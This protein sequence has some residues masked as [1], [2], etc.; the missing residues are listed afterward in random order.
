MFYKNNL[1]TGISLTCYRRADYL[2]TVIDSLYSSIK[3]SN[4]DISN[5]TLYVSIDYYDNVIPTIISN[6][7][8]INVKHIVNNPSLGCNANTKQAL[9]MSLNNHD[10]TIH[11]EDDTVLT[12]DAIRFFLDSLSNFHDNEDIVCISGYNKTDNLD[13]KLLSSTIKQKHFTCWGC[14]F[15]KH[16]FDVFLSNWTPYC[17]PQNNSSSW[18]TYLDQQIFQSNIYNLYQIKP[19]ISRIQNIGAI[20]GTWVPSTSFH[21]EN[22]LSPYTSDNL[23]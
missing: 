20:D 22:H 21:V 17:D 23:L 5:T 16:K 15:W 7:D 10:A 18:D 13:N 6:I 3:Y 8:W 9:L 4:I 19:E 12:K 11:L 14:A 1:S 2:E